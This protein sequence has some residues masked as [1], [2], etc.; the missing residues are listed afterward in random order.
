ML[1]HVIIFLT[2]LSVAFG[3]S[4]LCSLSEAAALSLA[5]GQVEQIYRINKRKG[6]I[7]KKFKLNI[8]DPVSVIL[9]L[10]TTAHTIGATVAGAE[11]QVLFQNKY[12]TLFSIA[13]TWLML[14]FTE[15]LPKTLGIRYNQWIALKIAV[16]LRFLVWMF[17]PVMRCLRRLNR[18][19]E[20]SNPGLPVS[21]TEEIS[22]LASVARIHKQLD[23]NQERI[24]RQTAML[25][26]RYAFEV[27]VIAPQIKYLASSLTLAQ[28][29]DSIHADPHTRFPVVEGQDINRIL[30][31]VNFKEL[32]AW[33]RTNPNA[34]SVVGVMR[35]IRFVEPQTELTDVL[36][37]FVNEHAHIAVVTSGDINNNGAGGETLGMLTLEDILEEL[38]G[39][40][41]DEFDAPFGARRSFATLQR[42]R[43]E[44]KAV[45]EKALK[46]QK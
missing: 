35:K 18:P 2:G 9:L 16:P 22:A 14:Q 27:M 15:I 44:R 30:G 19:F 3:V 24:F 45:A 7:W 8:S 39:E 43:K 12:L 29:I 6:E 37:I 20:W 42:L 1:I 46:E 17:L 31:Y 28:A 33:A 32:I 13:F 5:P 26:D 23:S 4:T 38:F 21:T 41:E 36:K 11:F 34:P 10:N 25:K 40:L